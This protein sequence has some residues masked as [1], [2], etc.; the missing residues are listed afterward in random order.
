MILKVII[1]GIVLG[2]LLI[3]IC[4]FGIR[5]GAVGMVHLYSAE[6]QERCVKNGLITKDKIK[7]N[8]G[9]FKSVCVPGY[10]AYILI[11]VYAINGAHGFLSGFWQMLVI[12]SI[13][14]LMDRFLVDDFW[15]GCT[16]AWIIPGTE[17]LRPYIKAKD[18]QKKWLFGTVG[19]AIISALLSAIMMI[20]IH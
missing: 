7:R 15:V 20:F 6:V 3:L 11:C 1:E 18:K 10:L 17:D 4:A 8:A 19:M 16:K 2:I 5:H 9:I 14:N 13:M 12:L